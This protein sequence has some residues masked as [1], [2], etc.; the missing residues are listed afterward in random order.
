MTIEVRRI[1]QHAKNIFSV[2]FLTVKPQIESLVQ[3]QRQILKDTP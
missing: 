2:F 3:V 1:G